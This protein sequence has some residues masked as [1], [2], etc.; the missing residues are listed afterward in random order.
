VQVSVD[1]FRKTTYP[2]IR[3]IDNASDDISLDRC[4]EFLKEIRQRGQKN[5]EVVFTIQRGNI[6]EI[7]NTERLS[8]EID[9]VVPAGVPV[10]FKFATGMGADRDGEPGGGEFLPSLEQLKKL[11]N[12][13]HSWYPAQ[14]A[15][16]INVQFIR[17]ATDDDRRTAIA[18]GYPMEQ[19]RADLSRAKAKCEVMKHSMFIDSYG[20]VFPCCYLFNDNVAHW[21]LRE[22][23]RV[24]VWTPSKTSS[25]RITALRAIWEGR[26]YRQMRDTRLSDLPKAACGRCT[27]HMQQNAFLTK[28]NE[29]LQVVK[30]TPVS[31]DRA[32]SIYEDPDYVSVRPV[33]L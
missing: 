12:K 11:H 32:L 21:S 31:R 8:K 16:P 23:Y 20:Q 7:L 17:D 2:K 30:N 14:S 3:T 29:V 5:L 15:R 9:E 4:A 28:V 13:W 6:D 33:W 27:R 10:R 26:Q 25:T 22:E 19:L 1:S 18:S 24:G